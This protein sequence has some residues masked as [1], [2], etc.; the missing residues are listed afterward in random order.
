MAFLPRGIDLFTMPVATPPPGVTS[1]F[2]DPESL[3]TTTM[4]VAISILSLTALVVSVRLFSNYHAIRG[5]G[6]NDCIVP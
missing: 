1:N 6:W 5:L 4:S 3:A 2:V